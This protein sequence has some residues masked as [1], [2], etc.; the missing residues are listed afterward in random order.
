MLD[1][2]GSISKRSTNFLSLP[3]YPDW[4]WGPPRVL[5]NV[6]W[7]LR[8]LSSRVEWLGY[9]TDHLLPLSTEVKKG[10][11]YISIPSYAF[12]EWCIIKQIRL[13]GVVLG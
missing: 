12:M 13:H 11:S 7:V 5:S 10:W 3:P 4:F 8:A 1:E 9:E 6:Q 2:Q